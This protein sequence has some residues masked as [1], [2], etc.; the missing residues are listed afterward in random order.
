M[1]KARNR[2][3]PMHPEVTT[4]LQ[5]TTFHTRG[6]VLLLYGSSYISGPI[7]MAPIHFVYRPPSYQVVDDQQQVCLYVSSLGAYTLGV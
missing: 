7:F 5:A 2:L 3:L 6:S 1:R 4:R